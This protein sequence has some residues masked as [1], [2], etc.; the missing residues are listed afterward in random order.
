MSTG[1]EFRDPAGITRALK[2]MLWTS[3]VVDAGAVFSGLLELSLLLQMQAGVLAGPVMTDAAQAR[4]LR[5]RAIG[6]VQIMLTAVTVI[7]FAR[8]IYVLNDN[9]R[10]PGATGP[11]FTPGWAIGSFFVPFANL[12]LPYLAM[13][14][15]WQVSADPRQ[16]QNQQPG[17][18]LPWWWFLWIA[19]NILGQVSYGM[20][21]GARTLADLTAV[22]AVTDVANAV[23]VALGFVALG[24]VGAIAGMQRQRI[25]EWAYVEALA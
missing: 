2:V 10:R 3:L 9:K 25:R 1:R 24:L 5:Q 4:D 12:W 16:W 18:L 14:E 17:R 20:S 8:W 22:S 15:L 23:G 21:R 6:L 7:I 13:K 19:H 11:L